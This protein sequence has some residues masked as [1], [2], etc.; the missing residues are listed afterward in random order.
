MSALSHNLVQRLEER[1]TFDQLFRVSDP[2]RVARSFK[3][4]GP[5]LEIDSYQDTVYYIFNFKS[6][7]STTGLRHQGYLKFFKPKSGSNTPLQ[8]VDCLV[9]CTCPDYRYRWAW[10]NKQRQSSLVGPQSLN[11]AWNKAPRKTNPQGKPGLCKHILAAREY[12]YGL[13]SSFPGDEPDTSEKLNKL[14]RYATKRWTD[15]PAQ[16]QQAK[17]RE[18]E[19]QQRI[20][21]RNI[22]GKPVEPVEVEPVEMEPT[23]PPTA[24]APL[25]PQAPVK[26]QKPVMPPPPPVSTLEEPPE[27]EYGLYGG[28]QTKAE[29]DFKRRSGAGQVPKPPRPFMRK[30]GPYGGYQTKA[31]QDFKRRQGLGDSLQTATRNFFLDH[32]V[33]A[34]GENMITLT[35]AKK[36]VQEMEDEQ[37]ALGSIDGASGERAAGPGMGEEPLEPSE[38][39]ISDSAVG[40]D[41]EGETVLSLLSQMRDSLTVLTVALAPEDTEGGEFGPEGA[42]AGGA[43]FPGGEG[44]PEGEEG[45]GEGGAEGEGPPEEGEDE[46]D[47][48]GVPPPD[49]EVPDEG[50][51]RKNK[52]EKDEDKDTEEFRPR[53]RRPVA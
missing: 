46:S 48:P 20:Q 7:P 22:Y 36:L 37:I 1:M 40:A 28:Y 30:Y 11:Q 25:K 5:P 47:M 19:L 15:F 3:V 9:D 38:P 41:T 42:P 8:H 24:K 16:V 18:R 29:Q 13:L 12:I 52:D 6:N 50:P 34:N 51:K 39:P 53:N 35:E 49:E 27:G 32:V 45:P 2:K 26:P 4:R 43:S 31:E 33:N 14:T 21:Q 17:A 23:L 44:P 10:A